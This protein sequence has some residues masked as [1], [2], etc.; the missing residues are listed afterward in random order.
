MI[1]YTKMKA[2]ELRQDLINSGQYTEEEAGKI[3]GKGNL[4]EAH[5]QIQN[6]LDVDLDT[7]GEELD[8]A[9]PSNDE[10]PVRENSG[11]EKD[12][13]GDIVMPPYMSP[14][15][16]DFVMSQFEEDELIDEVPTVNG[17]RR[18]AETL[19]GEIVTSGPVQVFPTNNASNSAT[20]VYQLVIA[21]KMALGDYIGFNEDF[22]YP[23]RTFSAVASASPSN[24]D[25]DVYAKFPEAISETRAEGRALR[26]ALG[27]KVVSYEELPTAKSAEV[28]VTQE[29][30][31]KTSEVD[32]TGPPTTAQINFIKNK[33]GHM[34]I[35]LEKFVKHHY[36]KTVEDLTFTDAAKAVKLMNS[37]QSQSNDSDSIPEEILE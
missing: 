10:E 37:Y 13:S 27:L 11:V 20:T 17:M 36:N 18:L 31:F 16:H 29:E 5:K 33:C 6:S 22:Q 9:E 12:P 8:F 21:W 34:K 3:K 7:L 30:E 15:W 32:E 19:L 24:V 23:T 25:G 2:E 1:D 4:V 28:K 35:S 26:K 14:K